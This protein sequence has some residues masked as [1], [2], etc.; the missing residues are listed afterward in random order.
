MRYLHFETLL[1]SDDMG[2]KSTAKKSTAHGKIMTLFICVETKISLCNHQLVLLVPGS[3]PVGSVTSSKG[4]VLA[5]LVY[6]RLVQFLFGLL[7]L[8]WSLF[9]GSLPAHVIT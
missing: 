6:A 1:Q 7:P 2:G 5:F 4:R 3:I 9:G 8:C